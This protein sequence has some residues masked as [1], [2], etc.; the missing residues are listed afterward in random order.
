MICLPYNRVVPVVRATPG[1]AVEATRF[2]SYRGY[3]APIEA[4]VKDGETALDKRQG[5]G[6]LSRRNDPPSGGRRPVTKTAEEENVVRV[7]NTP[8]D[9]AAAIPGTPRNSSL[10]ALAPA[11]GYGVISRSALFHTHATA[12]DVP[13]SGSGDPK[14]LHW[15]HR[16]R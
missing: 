14:P 11:R 2:G 7:P 16:R 9:I 8:E 5:Q 12:C 3:P 15:T 6:N 1:W 13:R 4:W 10:G